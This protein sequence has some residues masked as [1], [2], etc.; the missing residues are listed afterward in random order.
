MN[1]YTTTAKYE[2]CGNRLPC[3]LCRLTNSIC[4]MQIKP[5]EVTCGTGVTE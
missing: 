5:Y 4:P 1:E 2:Y 3:G